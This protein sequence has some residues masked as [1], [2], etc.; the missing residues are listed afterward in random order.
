MGLRNAGEALL[1]E[2][3]DELDVLSKDSGLLVPPCCLCRGL[4]V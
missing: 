2:Q 4:A 1:S 3:G